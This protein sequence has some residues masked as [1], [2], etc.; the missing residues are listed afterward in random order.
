[1][2]QITS[3]EDEHIERNMGKLHGIYHTFLLLVCAII[4]Q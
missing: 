2:S 4:V 1:M 3:F